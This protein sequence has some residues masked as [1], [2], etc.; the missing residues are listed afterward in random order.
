MTKTTSILRSIYK[1]PQEYVDKY[2]LRISE[3]KNGFHIYLDF[4]SDFDI[5]YLQLLRNTSYFLC[6]S[7]MRI[8]GKITLSREWY[9]GEFEELLQRVED[10]ALATKI[11]Q[12]LLP[13]LSLID[14][15]KIRELLRERMDEAKTVIKEIKKLVGCD[16][17]K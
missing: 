8:N 9:Y 7:F 3:E 14:I 16:D 1:I 6:L 17:Y 11:E 4:P 12:N 15:L 2:N 10:N 5:K 13:S